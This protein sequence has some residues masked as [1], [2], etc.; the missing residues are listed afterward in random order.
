[1]LLKTNNESLAITNNI[2]FKGTLLDRVQRCFYHV[3]VT[4]R[5]V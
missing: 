2:Q 1:M 3:A 4:Y 5:T